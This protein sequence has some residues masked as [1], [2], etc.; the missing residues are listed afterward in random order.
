MHMLCLI[1]YKISSENG[2]GFLRPGLET[3][4]GNGI[5]WSEIIGSGFGDAGGT[6]PPPRGKVKSAAK[7]EDSHS[8]YVDGVNWITMSCG[9]IYSAKSLVLSVNDATLMWSPPISFEEI[10]PPN[11]LMSSHARNATD[12]SSTNASLT[13]TLSCHLRTATR[14]L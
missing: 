10:Q 6:P 1:T 5:F 14:K 13:R 8:M 4:M 11:I 2:Y 12:S 3:G 9:E 7:S